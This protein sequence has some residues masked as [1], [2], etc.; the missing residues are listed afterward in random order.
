[1]TWLL[2]RVQRRWTRAVAGLEDLSYSERLN[3][4]NLFS[5]Q[6]RLLRNDLKMVWKIFNGKCAVDPDQLFVLDNSVTRGHDYKLFLPRSNL[7]VRRRYFSVRVIRVWN[8]LGADTVSSGSLEAFKRLLH[9]DLGQ[10][11]FQ[12]LD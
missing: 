2:E 4:L 12:Y 10:R 1:M 3:R 6:G 9:R 11:L 5:F 8:S 7:E